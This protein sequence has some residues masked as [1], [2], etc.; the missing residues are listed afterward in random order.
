ML[1]TLQK[2]PLWF[3]FIPIVWMATWLGVF[4]LNADMIWYDEYWSIWSAGGAHYGPI[5]IGEIWSRAVSDP[6][7]PPAYY[8][9]LAGWETLVGGS[10]LAMRYMSLVM[11]I[12][13]VAWT[14][15]LGRDVANAQVAAISA[16]LLGTSAFFATYLHELR[17]YTMLALFST[18]AIALY[19]RLIRTKSPHW[20]TQTLFVF[21]LAG[22]CYS[23]YLALLT[24]PALALYHLLFV[25]K[26][27]SWW[28]IPILMGLG[29][30]FF[31]PWI[32]YV[33]RAVDQFASSGGRT[34][35]AATT[36]EVIRLFIYALSNGIV[37]IPALLVAR[38]SFRVQRGVLLLA[39]LA[40][41]IFA[42]AL[43]LNYLV[44]VLTHT[45]Y[46]MSL[47]P[48]LTVLI[49]WAL[50]Q[51]GLFRALFICVI[52]ITAGVYNTYT[53]AFTT[54]LF[55][56]VHTQFF[57]PDLPLDDL[58]VYLRDH[59]TEN[60]VI[61]LHAP[62]APWAI[63]GGFDFALHGTPARYAIIDELA[64]EPG[65][66][67]YIT[68]MQTFI[69]DAGRIWLAV[70]KR[71]TTGRLDDFRSLL[72]MEY[73]HCG[74]IL[75]W[76]DLYIDLYA[77]SE[78]FCVENST[79]F[80]AVFGENVTLKD[81]AALTV[82]ENMLTVNTTWSTNENVPIQTY[83]VGMYIFNESEE[84]VLQAQDF[85]LP[86]GDFTYNQTQI[87]VEQLPSGEYTITVAVYNW[88][89]GERLIPQQVPA[90]DSA[91][92]GAFTV[93]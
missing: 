50:V 46:L 45:R 32:G 4:G 92:L 85:S 53:P 10:A 60:D 39:F 69:G 76:D 68:Q 16:L 26:N 62:N 38:L 5:S 9:M 1:N 90:S 30:L 91:L 79:E 49:A 43:L 17:L 37:F 28:R 27:R 82:D 55:R 29:V 86:M 34:D 75:D 51:I 33:L 12:L 61:A 64:G 57:R 84:F 40:V 6:S 58:G 18:M 24:L 41:L 72:D 11:G 19:W 73:V 25:E 93:P 2:F 22:V 63:S 7:Q 35:T 54:R 71:D 15:R 83:S 77:R 31:I 3:W 44:S 48:I 36:G 88:Q 65:T 78:I 20:I 56:D 89:T 23:H 70:E 66:D 21:S 42:Q 87:P 67:E 47:W 8:F 81:V 14:Y 13:T 59:A 74:K 80:L 52:W